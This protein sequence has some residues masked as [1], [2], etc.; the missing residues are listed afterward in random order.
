M[1]YAK[2]GFLLTL[3]VLLNVYAFSLAFN[4]G[5]DRNQ[6]S[7]NFQGTG[8]PMQFLEAEQDYVFD[9][10]GT[11]RVGVLEVNVIRELEG[12]FLMK[13][14]LNG[15][16]TRT[17][18]SINEE[19]GAFKVEEYFL[20]DKYNGASPGVNYF[21]GLWNFCGNTLLNLAESQDASID[22]RL[23]APMTE[24][25]TSKILPWLVYARASPGSA[26]YSE[27]NIKVRP[28]LAGDKI[29]ENTPMDNYAL[30]LNMALA[31]LLFLKMIG[32]TRLQKTSLTRP[33][34]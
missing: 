17:D 10:E 7:N 8:A 19:L 6:K 26:K 4:L 25:A 20:V 29:E 13:G 15:H 23:P 28:R 12:E 24:K 32:A 16:F 5:I 2:I 11:D 1:Y 21:S 34:Y 9:F 33:L 30:Y 14:V 18:G 22:C 3:L 27:L 31:S